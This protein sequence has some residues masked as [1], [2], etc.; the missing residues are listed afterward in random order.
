ME[1]K[2]L[3][4]N[5]LTSL[6][7][8][9]VQLFAIYWVGWFLFYFIVVGFIPLEVLDAKYDFVDWLSFVCAAAFSILAIWGL[10]Y[11]KIHA[12]KETAKAAKSNAQVIATHCA[13]LLEKAS[14]VAD[15]YME[16]EQR[17]HAQIVEG[18]TGSGH[19]VGSAAQFRA[20][21]EAYPELKAN[22]N[23]M[24]L[25]EQIERAEVKIA[26]AKMLYNSKVEE[27]NALL[28][29]F[30]GMIFKGRAKDMEYYKEPDEEI[31]DEELGLDRELGANSESCLEKQAKDDLPSTED[32]VPGECEPPALQV[33][34]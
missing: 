10:S 25:L 21:V 31:S 33:E 17:L 12:A 32:M 5:V 26:N 27:Y 11:N 24:R 28:H 34:E 1:N 19:T 7:L 16:H 8:M 30:P 3:T 20:V 13:Q 23:V 4:K 15:K 6:L 2:P 9:L 29:T 18:R 14:R 22:E